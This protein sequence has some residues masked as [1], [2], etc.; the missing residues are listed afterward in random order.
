MQRFRRLLT[1][2]ILVAPG[3]LAS[4]TIAFA[5]NDDSVERTLADG[6]Q[7][8]LE[9]HF[10]QAIRI[11]GSGLKEHP[12]DNRLRL[13]LGRA[14]LSNGSDRQALRLF[15]EILAVEPDNRLASLEL[16]RGLGY[17]RQFH[18]SD[19]IYEQL[20]QS[21]AADEAAAIGLASN[22]LHEKRS[23]QA[24]VVIDSALAFHPNSL[25]LQEYKD[26]IANG[27][28]GGEERPQAVRRNLVEAGVDYVNDS[29][30]NH[31]WRSLQR[32]DFGIRPGLNNRFSFEQQFQHSRDD[33]FEAVE[34]FADQLRW[35]PQENL[36]LS[37]GGGAVRYNN[38]DVHAIYET[39]LACQVRRQLVLE[40][41]FSRVPIIPDAEAAMALL[42]QPIPEGVDSAT[43]GNDQPP[44]CPKCYSLDIIFREREKP[45]ADTGVWLSLS[46]SVREKVCECRSCGYEWDD[47][48]NTL[49]G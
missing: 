13:E 17:G 35:R 41:A 15:R 25:R 19:R 29:A 43:E 44:R 46:P 1:V 40:A 8:M 16:A 10:G 39:S 6:Q 5:S 42:A 48:D 18:E 7:A 38:H 12:G 4:G 26:R 27:L 30:G 14:Y 45:K 9:R 31:S 20:L 49:D 37:A 36:L 34:N 24:R 3:V 21:N 28:L 47:E 22:L 32:V 11:L 2:I 23:S 33:S